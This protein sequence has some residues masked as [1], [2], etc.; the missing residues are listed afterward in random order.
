MMPT[1]TA[2]SLFRQKYNTH[3][4]CSTHN[5]H[6]DQHKTKLLVTLTLST[7]FKL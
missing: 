3:S 1:G 2:K 5:I 6:G 4:D 7:F